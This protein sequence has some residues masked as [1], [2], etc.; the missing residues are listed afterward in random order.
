MLIPAASVPTMAIRGG[1]KA[2]LGPFSTAN[3][4]IEITQIVTA[5]GWQADEQAA[6][7]PTQAWNNK[8]AAATP[9]QHIGLTNTRQFSCQSNIFVID[10][11][12]YSCQS[13]IF[14]IDTKNK[15]AVPT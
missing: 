11:R 8:Q 12:Q 6:A 7:T 10:T 13:N 14:V 9:A 3:T 15:N 5:A 1:R 4:F 2:A